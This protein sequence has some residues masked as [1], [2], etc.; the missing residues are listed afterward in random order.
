MIC[1]NSVCIYQHHRFAN[2]WTRFF[3]YVD[4]KKKIITIDLIN[5]QSSPIVVYIINTEK[6]HTQVL[7]YSIAGVDDD[8]D[9]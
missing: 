9:K 1:M 6:T 2:K 7:K 4:K 8:D 3:S 5:N